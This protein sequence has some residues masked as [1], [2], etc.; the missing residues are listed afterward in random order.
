MI[1]RSSAG[2]FWRVGDRGLVPEKGRV[3]EIE[4]DIDLG[5]GGGVAGGVGSAQYKVDGGF[6]G[7]VGTVCLIPTG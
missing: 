5:A 6:V 3:V 1:S 2:R 7:R 4:S